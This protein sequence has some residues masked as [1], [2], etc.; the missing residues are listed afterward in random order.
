MG[1]DRSFDEQNR[2]ATARMRDLVARLSDGD[3]RHPVG[4]HWTVGVAFAHL[5]FWDGQ[6]IAMLDASEQVQQVVS[7]P[8]AIAVNDISLPLWRAIPPQE[9]AAIAIATA[10][11]LD[12]RLATYAPALLEQ[13]AATNLDDVEPFRHRVE[14][15]DEIEQALRG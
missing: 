3:L 8:M 1:V 15:L 2:A 7:L 9:A 10:E 5:A 14:H 11:Q 4:E 6:V 12:Q 13:I